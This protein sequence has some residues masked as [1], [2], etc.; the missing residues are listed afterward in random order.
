MLPTACVLPVPE[1][2]SE[3]PQQLSWDPSTTSQL[4]PTEAVLDCDLG[5]TSV[6]PLRLH[7]VVSSLPQVLEWGSGQGQV[8]APSAVVSLE[9]Q[10]C[11]CRRDWAPP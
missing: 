1:A 6:I 11:P 7:L 4:H 2:A 8:N 10:R 9:K 5:R 3:G